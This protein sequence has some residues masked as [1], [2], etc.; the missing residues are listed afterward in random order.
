M[1]LAFVDKLASQKSGVKYSSVA[2]DV[3]SRFVSVQTMKTKYALKAFKKRFPKNTPKK[4]WVDKGTEYGRTFKNV[5]R[6]KN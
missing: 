4:L 6:E 2:V 5:C 3:F 1:D